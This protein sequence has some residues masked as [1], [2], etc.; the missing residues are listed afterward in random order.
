MTRRE[1]R[2]RAFELLFET[3]FRADESSER[4][5]EIATEARE[6][7]KD[8]YIE[9]VYFGVI[10]HRDQLD[11]MLEKH[12][13][14]WKVS[15]MSRV[16]R[17]V[18]RLAAYEILFM[19]KQIPIRVSINEAIE[20]SKKFDNEKAKGFINGIL[21]AVKNDVMN[22]EKAEEAPAVDAAP[23]EAEAPAT[24]TTES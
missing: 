14:G 9:E 4:I 8:K 1:A 21:N 18:L 22:P 24:E 19:R 23:A 2:E 12:A 3:D 6:I 7:P 20:L 11:A 13:K 5:Y 10:A 15:R 17:S 16:S